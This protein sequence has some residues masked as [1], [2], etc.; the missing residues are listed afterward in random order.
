MLKFPLEVNDKPCPTKKTSKFKR[1]CV[2]SAVGKN[3]LHREWIKENPDFDLHLIIYD[4]S[5]DKFHNDTGFICCNKGYKLGL[6]Y[7]YLQN[8]LPF[9]EKYDYFFLPDDDILMDPENISKLFQI[10][11]EYHLQIAQPAL[12]DSYYFYEHTLRD[13][14]CILHYTNFVEIMAPCFSQKALKKVLFTFDASN[15][16]WGIEIHWPQLIGFTGK[17][18]AIIDQVRAVHTRPTQSF[19]KQNMDE[20]NEYIAKHKLKFKIIQTGYILRKSEE[21]NANN[22]KRLV[23]SRIMYKHLDR[24]LN[25]IA[26][27]FVQET[28][29]SVTDI[30]GLQGLTGK[31][32]FLASY[33]RISEKRKYFDAAFLILE[34]AEENIAQIKNDMSFQS[35]LPCISWCIEYFAQHGFIENKTDEILEEVC[36]YFNNNLKKGTT[37]FDLKKL[38]GIAQHYIARMSNCNF[39]T[40]KELNI[41][42]KNTLIAIVHVINE[43]SKTLSIQKRD[44]ESKSIINGI[45]LLR[46]AKD[47]LVLPEIDEALNNAIEAFKKCISHKE[48]SL[49]ESYVFILISESTNDAQLKN[50]AIQHA[51][52]YIINSDGNSSFQQM[53]DLY[54]LHVLYQQT[55]NNTFKNAALQILNTLINQYNNGSLII[56]ASNGNKDFFQANQI[57]SVG[58]ILVSI[59]SDENMK[60]NDL[61]C[62]S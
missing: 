62:F 6:I 45:L 56:S 59:L 58:L 17:E 48:L 7:N 13:K 41:Q 26:D 39:D 50:K 46:K 25:Q 4:D 22:P 47:V 28:Y 14:F 30:I 61:F 52:D 57:S 31:A 60:L 27:L 16:G 24:L 19:S 32:L 40:N 34:K 1:N 18:I 21:R 9:L 44:T 42:E 37:D 29:N 55:Q 23:A 11:E 38:I 12:S 51:S 10:M 36:S 15:S 3:S 5:F 49:L 35:G 20:F 54:L 43:W 8:T 2:I 53:L 33:S